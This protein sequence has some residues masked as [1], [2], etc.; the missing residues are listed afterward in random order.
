[1]LYI[2]SRGKSLTEEEKVQINTLNG[3]GKRLREIA[4]IVHKSPGVVKNYL[5]LGMKY[6]KSG[7]KKRKGVLSEREK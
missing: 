2:V 5:T 6:G 3:A 4:R 1:M 7:Y